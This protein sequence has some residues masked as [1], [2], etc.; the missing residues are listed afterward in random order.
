MS[1]SSWCTIESDP[2]TKNNMITKM[3][4]FTLGVFTELLQMIGVKGVQ[5]EELYTLDAEYLKSLRYYRVLIVIYLVETS[6]WSCVF[7]Q[8]AIRKR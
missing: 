1:S 6:V 2:G 7:V 3:L 4:N 5:M 8:M